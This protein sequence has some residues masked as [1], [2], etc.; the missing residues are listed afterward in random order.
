MPLSIHKVT[1][2]PMAQLLGAL[3]ENL[4]K[5]RNYCDKNEINGENFIRE[6]LAS[7]MMTLVEQVQRACVNATGAVARLTNSE[8]PEFAEDEKTFDDLQQRITETL[9]YLRGYSEEQFEGS[10]TMEVEVQTRVALLKFSGQ[11]YL[12]QFAIPQVLFHVTTAHCIMRNQG[13]DIGKRD[14]LGSMDVK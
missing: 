10:E 5:A 9:S 13:V 3:A 2:I 14:F 8:L 12:L 1:V 11:D 4:E 7:D 6:S